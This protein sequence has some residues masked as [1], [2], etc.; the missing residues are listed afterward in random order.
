MGLL[1]FINE[2]NIA[3]NKD[4]SY[5]ERLAQLFAA[6]PAVARA[7]FGLLYDV[8]N[9]AELFLGVELQEEAEEIG[10]MTE[11]LRATYMPA[12][13]VHFVSNMR[14]PELLEYVVESNFP[15]YE[16]NRPTPLNMA[17]MKCWF[18]PARYKS[19]LIRQVKNGIV[20]TL[21]KDFNPFGDSL[22][23]QTYI[24]NGKEFIPLFSNV[25]M[26]GKSGMTKLPEDLTIMEFDWIKINE[27]VSGN[28]RE[29]FYVLNPGTS[30][31]V[32][33]VA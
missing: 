5:V 31:E 14:E 30:F 9:R 7:Y 11:K 28:L 22:N 32:E 10:P 25:E 2:D 13:L 19:D 17:V 18:N 24:R 1:D 20:T 16:R 26:I 8:Q 27:A 3:W 21:F 15:F 12:R 23:F 33:F 29:H 4:E 6:T